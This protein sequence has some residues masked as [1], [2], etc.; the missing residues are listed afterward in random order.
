VA[1]LSGAHKHQRVLAFFAPAYR[2]FYDL[3]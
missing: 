3:P 2:W 1:D